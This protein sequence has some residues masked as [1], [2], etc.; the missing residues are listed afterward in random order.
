M[1]AE[2]LPVFRY[3]PDPLKTGSIVASDATCR[4]CNRSRGYV[5]A[6]PVYSKERGLENSLCPWCI[7]D[8]TAHDRFTAEFTDRAGVGDYGTW[9]VVPDAVDRKSTRL[10][11]SH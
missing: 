10:N 8:G 6:G 3:H 5:Y 9:D 7:A 1:T 11:C 2:G 4:A